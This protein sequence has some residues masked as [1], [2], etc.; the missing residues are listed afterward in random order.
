MLYSLLL[1]QK[2]PMTMRDDLP[3]P[4]LNAKR[5]FHRKDALNP[6]TVVGNQRQ[7]GIEKGQPLATIAAVQKVIS[8][9]L[10]LSTESYPRDLE[11]P[12]QDRPSQV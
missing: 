10:K 7:E 4:V 12:R 1:G 6:A 2:L 8:K 3:Y 5:M 11:L 9:R